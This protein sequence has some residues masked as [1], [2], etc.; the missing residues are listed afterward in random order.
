MSWWP[1]LS[2]LNNTRRDV[3]W[4]VAIVAGVGGAEDE[5]HGD[6]S[7]YIIHYLSSH[8]LQFIHLIYFTLYHFYDHL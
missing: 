3:A 5:D 1:W 6:I 2:D 8:K 7:S 4:M